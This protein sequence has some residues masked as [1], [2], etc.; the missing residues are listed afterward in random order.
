MT[1]GG[2]S[3]VKSSSSSSSMSKS[4]SYSEK[5]PPV[6]RLLVVGVLCRRIG[7]RGGALRLVPSMLFSRFVVIPLFLF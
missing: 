7:S 4:W 6:L 1:V 5:N 3:V 2:K